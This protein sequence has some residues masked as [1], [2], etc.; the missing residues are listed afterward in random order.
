[1]K[2]AIRI[3][4]D[5]VLT[6]LPLKLYFHLHTKISPFST[7]IFWLLIFPS[8]IVLFLLL[9]SN[10]LLNKVRE[11]NLPYNGMILTA[12]IGVIGASILFYFNIKPMN[13]LRVQHDDLAHFFVSVIVLGSLVIFW[14]A[15]TGITK[16]LKKNKYK[17]FK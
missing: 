14:I 9:I 5:F 7:T 1:M 17:G 8:T 11:L 2:L 10:V 3:L 16:L 4:S 13:V 6:Y 12:M 15:G